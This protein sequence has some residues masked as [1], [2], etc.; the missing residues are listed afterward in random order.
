MVDQ[1]K[2]ISRNFLSKAQSR[3]YIVV[4][5]MTRDDPG[6]EES[7]LIKHGNYPLIAFTHL[8]LCTSLKLKFAIV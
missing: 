3:Q 5:D 8:D 1:N 7:R 4:R 2:K 6:L